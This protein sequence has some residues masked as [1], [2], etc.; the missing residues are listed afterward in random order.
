MDQGAAPHAVLG[1]QAVTSFF[2]DAVRTEFEP[3]SAV[4]SIR[5]IV[6][7]ADIP[8]TYGFAARI[9]ERND[10]VSYRMIALRIAPM[11]G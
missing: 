6:R 1:N 8:R 2:H 7:T 5:T 10:E 9:T 4:S 3:L 11:T